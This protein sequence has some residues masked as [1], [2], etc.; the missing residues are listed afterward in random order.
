MIK[1]VPFDKCFLDKTSG[2]IKIKQSEYLDVGIIPI[3]DQGKEFIGGYTNDKNCIVNCEL[4]CLVYGDHS[5]NIKYLDVDFAIGA[6]GVKVLETTTLISPKFGYYFLKTVQLPEIGYERSFKYLKRINVPILPIVEQNKIVSILDKASSLLNKRELTIKLLNE[7]TRASFLKMFGDPV[8]NNKNWDKV[9]LSDFGD[10]ITGNT[11]SRKNPNF[12][13][14]NFIE[15]IKTDN[16]IKDSIYPTTAAEYLSSKG[17][18]VGRIASTGAVLVT[19]IAGSLSSIGR[20]A[21][22]NRRAAFNQQINA[23]QPNQNISS[24]FLLH[25]IRNSAQYIQSYATKGMKKIITKGDFQKIRFINPPLEL[26]VKF[27]NI[28]DEI[29]ESS[30]KIRNSKVDMTTLFN[31]LIQKVFNG[32]LNFNIDFELDGLIQKIDLQ[33]KDNDLSKIVG[34]IAY[35]QRLVDRLNDQEFKEKD[36]YDKAKNVVFQLMAVKEEERKVIQEYDEKSK[37]L[38]LTLK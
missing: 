1:K 11:P 27:E 7:L 20:T 10:I 38:K 19:C 6:D 31:S 5:R 36:L 37:S 18:N 23:I 34:D 8:I 29:N 16:I 3:I 14:A 21:L 24:T 28:V 15:W 17:A 22:L 30:I 4:P 26:Q 32:Q 12:Y 13:D 2:N 9:P 35:L 25:L 33:K